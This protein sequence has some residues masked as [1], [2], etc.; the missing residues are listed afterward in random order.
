MDAKDACFFDR[1]PFAMR[2]SFLRQA[3]KLLDQHHQLKVVPL[4][5]RLWYQLVP[6]TCSSLEVKMTD[7]AAAKGFASWLERQNLPLESIDLEIAGPEMML[8]EAEKL[9]KVVCNQVSLRNLKINVSEFAI[10]NISLSPLT[11]LTSLEL[12]SFQMGRITLKSIL[13][14]TQLRHLKLVDFYQGEE[15]LSAFVHGVAGSLLHLTTLDLSGKIMPPRPQQLLPLTSLRGLKDLRLSYLGV[16][17][18]SV[19]VLKQL[20]I[21]SA[22]VNIRAGEVGEVCSWLQ[23]GGSKIHVLELS[24]DSLEQLSLPEVELLMSTLR[25]CAPQLQSLSLSHLHQLCHSTGLASLTQLTRLMVFDCRFDDVALLRLSALTGL[26][27]LSSTFNQV[28]GPGGSLHCL[29]SSLQQLTC[30]EMQESSEAY[31]AA[32][33]AFGSRVIAFSQGRLMLRPGSSAGD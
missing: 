19:A 2:D 12:H 6:S 32:E 25:T 3:F 28:T 13:L 21:T 33:L 18:E 17:A 26:R 14:L 22:A 29:A 5:C 24:G 7:S 27:E 1:L 20:P 10:C 31:M 30:L 9:E 23:G 8:D 16:E 15:D 11:N 4:V